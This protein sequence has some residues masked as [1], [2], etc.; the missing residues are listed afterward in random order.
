MHGRAQV[1]PCATELCGPGRQRPRGHRSTHC[2]HSHRTWSSY[3][4]RMR[5]SIKN[6][7]PRSP[8]TVLLLAL[9]LAGSVIYAKVILKYVATIEPAHAVETAVCPWSPFPFPPVQPARLHFPTSLAVRRI[10]SP[11]NWVPAIKTWWELCAP[12]PD[13]AHEHLPWDSPCS[14]SS[15]VCWLHAEGPQKA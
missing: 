13:L 9:M 5:Q 14:P 8:R 4:R 7:D 1:H 15:C 11:H 3:Q 12:L 6:P 2:V 10:P